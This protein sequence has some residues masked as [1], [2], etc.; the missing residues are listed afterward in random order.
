[1]LLKMPPKNLPR[2]S[3]WTSVLEVTLWLRIRAFF[4]NRFIEQ[5]VNRDSH[6]G[7]FIL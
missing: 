1:M 6:S 3:V 4:F 5:L 2:S 7:V